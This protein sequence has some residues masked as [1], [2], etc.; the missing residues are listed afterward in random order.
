[1][2]EIS[3]LQIFLFVNVFIIG[4]I[5][6]YAVQHARAHFKPTSREV[7]KTNLPVLP[8]DARQR[9]LDE[10]EETYQKVIDKSAKSIETSFDATTSRLNSLL[11]K[12]GSD[13][14][15]DEM[16]RYKTTLESLR[17]KTAGSIDNAEA[18][19]ASHQIQL[20]DKLV[21]RQSSIDSQLT[22]HQAKLEAELSARQGEIETEY[23]ER[24]AEYSKRQA[25]IEA[26][27]AE[28]QAELDAVLKERE[29]KLAEHQTLLENELTERQKRYAERQAE[30]DA[31]LDQE[32][33]NKR[34][35]LAQQ[36]DARLTESVLSF[37]TETLGH[38]VD[39][40]AQTTYLTKMLEEHKT[41]LTKGITDEG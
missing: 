27:L 41:E 25:E 16:Q 30:L 17:E 1:M 20:R 23:L 5:T 6:A 8:A 26:K 32:M 13:I 14:V 19:I 7:K 9:I 40:G 11:D 10:A 28:H 2:G 12:M 39:L 31:Q 34:Q 3:I 29:T 37:L 21:D 15:S 4:V 22:E 24:K 36:L 38:E 18:E 35:L 33:S